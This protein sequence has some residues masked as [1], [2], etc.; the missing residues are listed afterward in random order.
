M[1]IP[2]AG[3]FVYLKAEL[4]SLRLGEL[5][6]E[7]GEIFALFRSKNAFLRLIISKNIILETKYVFKVD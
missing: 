6:A 5:C 2:S 3:Y 1:L 4:F 7:L